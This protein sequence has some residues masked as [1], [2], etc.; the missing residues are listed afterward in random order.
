MNMDEVILCLAPYAEDKDELKQTLD[1]EEIKEHNGDFGRIT[2]VTVTGIPLYS[3]SPSSQYGTGLAD[4]EDMLDATSRY[5]FNKIEMYEKAK[6]IKELE[7]M[8]FDR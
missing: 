1:F 5:L 7:T 4:A 8:L 3:S 6:E 2:E